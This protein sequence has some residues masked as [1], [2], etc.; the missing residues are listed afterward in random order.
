M[1]EVLVDQ[2][3]CIKGKIKGAEIV[4]TCT[5]SR[6]A[7]SRPCWIPK[8]KEEYEEEGSPEILR[9]NL[10]SRSRSTRVMFKQLRE[11]SFKGRLC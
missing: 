2:F 8:F 7:H 5:L 10:I 1:G 4:E 9:S 3:F 11:G 6:K